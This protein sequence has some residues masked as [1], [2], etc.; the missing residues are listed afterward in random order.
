MA[1]RITSRKRVI[2]PTLFDPERLAV[3][4][5]YC[6][7]REMDNHIEIV[8][9]SC[10]LSTGQID[11]RDLLDKLDDTIA[12]IYFENPAYLGTLE[13]NAGEIAALARSFGAETIVGVDPLSLGIFKPPADYGADIVVGPT[14]PLGIPMNGGGGTGGFI[15]TH[16]TM[17]YVSEFNGFLVSID[18]TVTPGEYAFGLSRFH[19]TSYGS[20]EAGNDWTGTSVY[21]WAVA[22][23]VYMS[24]LG[25]K[26]FEELGQIIIS[27]ARYAVM[28]LSR[29]EGLK[30]LWPNS[31]FKE[32]VVNFDGIGMS[33][34][35]VNDALRARGIF[36]GKDLSAD[37]PD[38]GQSALY[39]VTEI[40]NAADIDRLVAALRE[41]KK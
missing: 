37:L 22:S 15:A 11:R 3:V 41:I 25:P 23:A 20:R 32:F 9:V 10:D 12:A 30:V 19:Q 21:L 31:H 16:D 1:T 40:H 8:K 38:L 27:R 24:L 18:Q 39:C 14:Q 28:S 36:G 6:G 5:T 35:E 7:S 4:E 26:G 17:K 13:T 33:V 34:Q 29:V 2:I